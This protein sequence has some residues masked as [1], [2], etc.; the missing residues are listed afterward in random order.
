[1]LF[2]IS[3]VSALAQPVAKTRVDVNR[4]VTQ[5]YASIYF[6][7]GDYVRAERLLTEQVQIDPTDGVSW[8]LLG[9]AQLERGSLTQA[10]YSFKQAV[11]HASG[12]T[13]RTALYNIADVQSRGKKEDAARQTLNRLLRVEGAEQAA[14][15]ALKEMRTGRPLPPYE[16][17]QR[18]RQSLSG[19]FGSG[20]DSNV[21]LFSESTLQPSD[22]TQ[23]GSAYLSP[24]LQYARIDSVGKRDLETRALASY[25]QYLD[26][27]SQSFNSLF[28]RIE[29][30]FG[31]VADEHLGYHD[32][33]GM[34]L[35]ATAL[36]LNGALG[37]FNAVG[38]L[39]YRA[40]LR[41]ERTWEWWFEAPLRYQYFRGEVAGEDI[42]SGPGAQ[43]AIG[44]RRVI[45]PMV[46]FAK[47]LGDTVL[48]TGDN[49]RA[50][51]IGL[52]V[53]VAFPL[54]NLG[55]ALQLGG[56]VL[57]TDYYKNSSDRADTSYGGFFGVSRAFWGGI[58][59]MLEYRFR[60]NA[61]T[62]DVATYRKHQVGLYLSY[63]FL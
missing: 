48:T 61:S 58:Q 16:D 26:Q 29:G 13:K 52:P 60:R 7:V 57:F 25:T 24:S 62:L 10:L 27:A 4:E 6:E 30:Q 44:Q 35:D 59:A 1:M 55:L 51:S 37:L 8:N 17:D 45:G 11:L 40:I 56:D 15:H 22:I 39:R 3:L 47:V 32:A 38:G 21:L 23:G 12:E 34:S 20:Y 2:L 63:D 28:G 14:R 42:R 36:N 18:K 5:T 31:S 41:S 46:L 49:F 19:T 53:T 54:T 33:V 50:W 9:L 43:V